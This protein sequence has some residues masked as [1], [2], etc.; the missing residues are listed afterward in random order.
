MKT[1]QTYSRNHIV[2]AQVVG[3]EKLDPTTKWQQ[4]REHLSIVTLGRY[5]RHFRD[6]RITSRGESQ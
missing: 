1:I 4:L 2:I 3:W 6:E 5:S